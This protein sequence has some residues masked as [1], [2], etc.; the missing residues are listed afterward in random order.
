MPYARVIPVLDPKVRGMCR[1]PYEGHPRG[2][3]NYGRVDRCPPKVAHLDEVYDLGSPFYAVWSTFALGEHA[4][5]MR[6]RHPGWSDRQLRCVLYWQGTARRR[7]REEVAAFR[8]ERPEVDWLVETTPE[9]MGLEVGK[10]VAQ[11]GVALPWPPA[12]L[13]YH[14]ALAGKK[15]ELFMEFKERQG[16]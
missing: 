13:V 11:V 2:C 3:P 8:R 9:A 5:K 4:A 15:K 6:E 12:E 14:V 10:T 1:L 7:L 16:E